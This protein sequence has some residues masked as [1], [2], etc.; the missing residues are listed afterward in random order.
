MADVK[1][2]GNDATIITYGLNVHYSI[3]AAD[4]LLKDNKTVEVIDLRSL[5][6]LDMDTVISSVNKTN[7]VIIVHEENLSIGVGA[8]ESDRIV[9]MAFSDLDAPVMRCT[10][11]DIPAMPFAPTLEAEFMP[12]TEKIV[13]SLRKL[14]EY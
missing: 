8:E 6:P 1:R 13:E 14:L 2:Q 5:K 9:E 4:V 11:P 12:T 3:Q 7:R 10:G